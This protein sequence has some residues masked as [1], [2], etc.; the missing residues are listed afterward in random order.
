MMGEKITDV[1]M[2]LVRFCLLFL[3]ILYCNLV[4]TFFF[5]FFNKPWNVISQM[6]L[7]QRNFNLPLYTFDNKKKKHC[8][9]LGFIEIEIKTRVVNYQINRQEFFHLRWRFQKTMSPP[10]GSGFGV[11]SW[12]EKSG[13]SRTKFKG[14]S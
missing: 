12:T 5:F 11:Q 10:I 4:W 8:N 14:S 2:G 9:Q 6:F 7:F 3:Q 13:R 1:I